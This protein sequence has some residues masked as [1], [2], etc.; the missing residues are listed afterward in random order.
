M[1]DVS[2]FLYSSVNIYRY[3]KFISLTPCPASN[4]ENGKSQFSRT[5]S[6]E[7]PYGICSRSVVTEPP[8]ASIRTVRTW[9]KQDMR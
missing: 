2:S 4:D 7:L 3:F 5:Y 8:V 6:N 1:S 9:L